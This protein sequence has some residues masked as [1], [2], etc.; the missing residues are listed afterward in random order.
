M[1]VPEHHP[2][3]NDVFFEREDE[4]HLIKVIFV[5]ICTHILIEDY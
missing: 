1:Y 3:T 5:D 2:E 4:A